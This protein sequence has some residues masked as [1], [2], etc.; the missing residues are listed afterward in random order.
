MLEITREVRR[1]I[2][3][4]ITFISYQQI[5]PSTERRP[6]RLKTTDSLILQRF[7]KRILRLISNRKQKSFPLKIR[8]K[9]RRIPIKLIL[10]SQGRKPSNNFIILRQ[11]QRQ[12][13]LISI[14]ILMKF[15]DPKI[16]VTC[17]IYKFKAD[18]ILKER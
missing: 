11:T 17:T 1:C 12:R 2:W 16:V 3:E 15:L 7:H 4:L 10:P 13:I 8:L 9:M 6:I 5:I 18:L 14:T